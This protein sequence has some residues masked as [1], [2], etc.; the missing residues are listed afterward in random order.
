MAK[1]KSKM[2]APRM[3]MA[4]PIGPSMDTAAAQKR[5]EEYQVK[6]DAR[7]IEDYAEL[8]KDSGRHS[9]AI[10]HLRWKS[11]MLDQ[12]EGNNEGRKPQPRGKARQGRRTAARNIGRA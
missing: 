10:D 5:E 8:R 1:R 11:S 2:K 12:L 7:R 4:V 6:D 9:K 3:S